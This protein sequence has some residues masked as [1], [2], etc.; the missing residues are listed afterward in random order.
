MEMRFPLNAET[1]ITEAIVEEDGSLRLRNP[2]PSLQVG[3]R[4]HLTISPQIA[5]LK[6]DPALLH[7]S[8]IR[9]DDPFGPAAAIEDWEVLLK[10]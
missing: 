6:T 3:T 7:G 5:T 2:V 1:V 8:V 10:C 4:V 9:Y